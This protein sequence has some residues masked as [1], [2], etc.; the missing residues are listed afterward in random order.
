MKIR[1]DCDNEKEMNSILELLNSKYSF[2]NTNIIKKEN[3]GFIENNYYIELTT[4]EKPMK[5]NTYVEPFEY[6]VGFYYIYKN[7]LAEI[8][9]IDIS[10]K[11]TPYKCNIFSDT[12][13]IV[14][15]KWVNSSELISV[16]AISKT[17]INKSLNAA[18]ISKIKKDWTSFKNKLKHNQKIQPK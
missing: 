13:R 14:N 9:K 4:D 18:T 17:N 3:F 8:I 7:N 15:S 6:K 12:G 16:S 1:I 10:D 5:N 2:S 11:S